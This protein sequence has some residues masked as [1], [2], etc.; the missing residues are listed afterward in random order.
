MITAIKAN[1]MIIA[2]KANKIRNRKIYLRSKEL[3]CNI[4]H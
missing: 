1:K 3:I 2:I 4:C